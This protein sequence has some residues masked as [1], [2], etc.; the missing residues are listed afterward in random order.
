V[1]PGRATQGDSRVE[2]LRNVREAIEL[3]VEDRP[4]AGDAVTLAD[5][6]Q[7][8]RF[9]NFPLVRQPRRPLMPVPAALWKMLANTGKL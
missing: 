8:T 1:L 4:A 5:F 9:A 2:A 7:Y 6:E 3:Y